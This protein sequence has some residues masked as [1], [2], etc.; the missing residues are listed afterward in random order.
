MLRRS[1]RAKNGWVYR[2]RTRDCRECVYHKRCVTPRAK[3][4]TVV[5]VDDYEA[6]LRARR[7]RLRWDEETKRLYNR[8]RWRAEGPHGV[9]KTQHGLRRAVRRGLA[10]VTIQSFLT[11][12]VMNLKALAAASALLP[13]LKNHLARLSGTTVASESASHRFFSYHGVLRYLFQPAA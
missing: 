3:V 6:L 7:R 9:G 11:A 5:I 4:R 8:H 1:S 2:A 12:A 13:W 10:N